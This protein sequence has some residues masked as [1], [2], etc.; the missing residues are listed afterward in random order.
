MTLRIKV[1]AGADTGDG[2]WCFDSADLPAGFR[3]AA[4]PSDMTT[5]GTSAWPG[6]GT[7]L[8]LTNPNVNQV[9]VGAAWN[10]WSA[11]SLGSGTLMVFAL[12]DRFND[13]S[14]AVMLNYGGVVPFGRALGEGVML[15]QSMVYLRDTSGD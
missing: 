8:D 11:I 15:Y 6:I 14:G 3:S 2:P 12:L 9:A 7:V 1:G 10:D 5:V 4:L 13:G